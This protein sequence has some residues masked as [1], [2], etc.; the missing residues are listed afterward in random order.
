MRARFMAGACAFLVGAS[1]LILAA[2]W[3][4][5]LGVVFG[6]TGGTAVIVVATCL[7]GLG[8]GSLVLARRAGR[9]S[10]PQSVT[11]GLTG[12]VALYALASPLLLGAVRTA[13]VALHRMLEPG[14]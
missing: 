6:A 1:S 13:F 10:R 8:T 3:S 11:A 4:R 2:V 7:A 14:P 9:S 12:A 5:Y